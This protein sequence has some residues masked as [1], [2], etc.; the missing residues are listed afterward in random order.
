M[1]T[2]SK[3]SRNTKAELIQMVLVLEERHQKLV[4]KSLEST[5]P[6]SDLEELAIEVADL[7]RKSVPMHTMDKNWN[8]L[9]RLASKIKNLKKAA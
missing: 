6:K 1:T 8:D 5:Q 4:N 9:H 3:L 2:A 7:I